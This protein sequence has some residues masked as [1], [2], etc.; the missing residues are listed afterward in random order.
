MKRK[1]IFCIFSLALVACISIGAT[2]AWLTSS[3]DSIVNTFTVGKITLTLDEAKT[4]RNVVQGDERTSEGNEY[5]LYKDAVLPKDPTVTVGSESQACYVFM[6]CKISD[7]LKDITDINFDTTHW[8]SVGDDVYV[9]SDNGET[10]TIVS[11]NTEAQKLPSLFTT[12]TVIDECPDNITSDTNITV[13]A[14]AYQSNDS[15]TLNTA[16][17][18]AKETLLTA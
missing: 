17:E 13:K 7:E 12:V 14:L 1:A 11:Y 6:S 16:T 15:S 9:Y 8:L 3:T 18:F 10:A 4:V 2:L 5:V